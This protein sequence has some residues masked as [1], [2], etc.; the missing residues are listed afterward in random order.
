MLTSKV[1]VHTLHK[2]AL[3]VHSFC[4]SRYKYYVT[5]TVNLFRQ[6]P[7][8]KSKKV[9]DIGYVFLKAFFIL[10]NI[11]LKLLMFRLVQN[12]SFLMFQNGIGDLVER[13][14]KKLRSLHMG[15]IYRKGRETFILYAEILN[16]ELI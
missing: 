13:V 6:Y 14:L 11:Y 5:F 15:G 8:T 7:S 16:L 2:M 1:H 3:D 9:I 4:S 12:G 10:K